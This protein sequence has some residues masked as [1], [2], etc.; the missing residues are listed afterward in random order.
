MDWIKASI[1]GDFFTNEF[2]QLEGLKVRAQW[3]PQ[4][5]KA[6]TFLPEA[7]ALVR[8]H[9]VLPEASHH[10]QSLA[11]QLSHTLYHNLP[12]RSPQLKGGLTASLP[13]YIAAKP[14]KILVFRPFQLLDITASSL[15]RWYPTISGINPLFP[16]G[17]HLGQ[18]HIL[19]AR[20]R[21]SP[22]GIC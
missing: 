12:A 17:P 20:A 21:M 5:T 3:D 2:G 15:S 14:V 11:H 13:S 10:R 16:L 22:P 4:I 7:R 18:Q 6:M 19:P 9:Q 8:S 1:K